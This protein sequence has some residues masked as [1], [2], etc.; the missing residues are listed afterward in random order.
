MCFL[1][2]FCWAQTSPVLGLEAHYWLSWVSSQIVGLTSLRSC[3]SQFLIS[4]SIIYLIY[5]SIYQS[6]IYL[7]NLSSIGSDSLEISRTHCL[8]DVVPSVS[9]LVILSFVVNILNVF[10]CSEWKI[11]SLNQWFPS[12]AAHW[13]NLGSFKN[14]WCLGPTP[15]DY[16][17]TCEDAAR[18]LKI[19]PGDANI[20]LRLRTTEAL[21]TILDSH[22][23][24]C[25]SH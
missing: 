5:L 8:H 11:L 12:L 3:D 22:S 13:N 19:F 24:F 25:L 4:L 6:S 16:Y 10:Q 14:Y 15:W 21:H 2:A 17:L 7:S 23:L 18:S 1:S 20:Q 9:A